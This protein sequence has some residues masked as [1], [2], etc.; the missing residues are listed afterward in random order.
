MVFQ[1]AA[2]FLWA[3]FAKALFINSYYKKV[4]ETLSLD[5]EGLTF[6]LKV[7]I[8][9][10]IVIYLV[11]YNTLHNFFISDDFGYLSFAKKTGIQDIFSTLTPK[12]G[13]GFIRPLPFF[14]WILNYSICKLDPFGYHLINITIHIM[15]SIL[16]FVLSFFIS[17]DKG[18]S[19]FGS[20]LFSI[21]PLHSEVN[22]W[23][24]CWFDLLVAF[25]ILLSCLLF[26]LYVYSQKR[27]LYILS[28]FFYPIA[29]LTKETG[30]ILPLL[31]ILLDVVLN[32]KFKINRIKL[33]LPYLI[34]CVFYLLWRV[35][36]LGG[37]G[38]YTDSF[39]NLLFFQFKP[40]GFLTS[41]FGLPERL[42]LPLNLKLFGR[43]IPEA[44]T[45]LCVLAI[46]TGIL[47]RTSKVN[48][49]IL[50]GWGLWIVITIIPVH[51]FLPVDNDL[52]SSRLFYLSS[53]GFFL[54]FAHIIFDVSNHIKKILSLSIMTGFILIYTV[55]TTINN[56]AWG[57]AAEIAHRIPLMVKY[58]YN[59]LPEDSRLVFFIPDNING[60][61]VY[62]NG[63]SES[64]SMIYQNTSFQAI[65]INSANLTDKERRDILDQLEIPDIGKSIFVFKW[66]KQHKILED[67]SFDIQKEPTIL[68][69]ISNLTY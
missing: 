30:I 16:V 8:L 59:E 12:K 46:A 49:Y 1:L 38:G 34:L 21:S 3:I 19:L 43:L 62:R 60:A 52:Q 18:C 44:V 9:I 54:L 4:P 41:I 40:L 53:A 36:S 15:N 65:N 63:I 7:S 10:S 47:L 27:Y 6:L 67:V 24:S 69:D 42:L 45:I 37:I 51:N 31:I 55:V 39:G 64:L 61:Y 17:R 23:I 56:S 48:R 28:I 57:K 13:D 35:I 22:T 29:L 26:G 32:K 68:K 20:L 14:L 2:I 66:N 33:Y 25:F 11:Y 58:Y 5:R 50:M